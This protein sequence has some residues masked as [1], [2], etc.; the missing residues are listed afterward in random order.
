MHWKIQDKFVVADYE[1]MF[2]MC[3]IFSRKSTKL[4]KIIVKNVACVSVSYDIM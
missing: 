3:I 2:E 4:R 1:E